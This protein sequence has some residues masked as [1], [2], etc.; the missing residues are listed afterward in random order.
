MKVHTLNIS[1]MDFCLGLAQC[2]KDRNR[3]LLC[4]LADLRLCD[5]GLNFFQPASV[6]MFVWRGRPRPRMCTFLWRV[7]VWR[8]RSC[9]RKIM[10]LQ[11][12]QTVLMAMRMFSLLVPEHLARQLFF[13]IHIHIHFGG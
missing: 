7:L 5:D 12:N 8:G 13:L 3:G 2:L 1:A 4:E 9:P 6:L 10:L 11:R